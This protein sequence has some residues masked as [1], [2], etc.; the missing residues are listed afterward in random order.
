M[1]FIC[2]I[3][4]IVFCISCSNSSNGFKKYERLAAKEMASGKRTDSI[5]L[6]LYLGM[7]A[8]DFYTVCWQMNRKG[9]IM[10]GYNNNYVLY[11]LN[12]DELRYPGSMNFYPD[13]LNEK[14]ARMRVIYQ[15][16][17]WAPWNKVLYADSLLVDIVRLY[18]TWY[19]AG[20]EFIQVDDAKKGTIYVKVDNNRQITIGRFD[21]MYVKVDFTDLI[22]EKQIKK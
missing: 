9:I 2:I 5:F 14:I 21:D 11:K 12:R 7:P 18:K 16:D 19:P 4:L 13:F 20:N 6:G 1:R 22:A 15:Y 8:K 10:D 17:G 3:F